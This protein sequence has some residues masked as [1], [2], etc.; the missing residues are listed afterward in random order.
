M[1]IVLSSFLIELG[2]QLMRMD[3]Q[4]CQMI[5]ENSCLCR[6]VDICTKYGNKRESVICI[7]KAFTG[8]ES[9]SKLRV[10]KK[11][12]ERFS[13]DINKLMG[14]VAY[15][16]ESEP[17][18]EMED[19]LYNLLL[20]YCM[21]AVECPSAITRTRGLKVIN[22]IV[23]VNYKPILSLIHKLA[24]LTQDLWWEAQAQLLILCAQLLVYLATDRQDMSGQDT[25]D[26][27]INPNPSAE[28]EAQLVQLQQYLLSLIHQLFHP[29]TNQNILHVGLVYLSPVTNYYLNLNDLYLQIIL[30]VNPTIRAQLLDITSTLVQRPI[31]NGCN[32]FNYKLTGII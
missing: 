1:L 4:S 17:D 20:Y 28:A 22:E 19:E 10:L 13:S 15:F 18:Q 31:H 14:F 11:V 12:K 7:I 5:F 24:R 26:R 27:P 23:H 3:G 21:I 16:I 29:D 30:H 32:T 8:C 9:D 25:L 2:E 6:L